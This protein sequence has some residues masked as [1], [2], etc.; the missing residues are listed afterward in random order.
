LILLG[1]LGSIALTET[2]AASTLNAVIVADKVSLHDGDGEQFD[3]VV[4]VDAAQGHRVQAFG[5]RGR[6][7]QVRTANGHIGWVDS[8]HVE[9]FDL[10]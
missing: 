5:Q 3:I 6:W 1:S 8:K 2:E 9:R 4:S 10:S 7:T